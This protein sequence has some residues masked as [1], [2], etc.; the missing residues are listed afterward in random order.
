MLRAGTPAMT[1]RIGLRALGFCLLALGGGALHAAGDAAPGDLIFADGFESGGFSAWAGNPLSSSATLQTSDGQTHTYFYR[2]PGTPAPAGGRPVLLWLH[3]DGGSG[4]GGFGSQFYPYTDPDGAIV[5]TPSGI[6]QTW[7]HAADDLPGQPQDSQFLSLLIDDLLANGL[8]GSPVDPTRIYLGGVSRGAYMPY[9]LLQRPSTKFRFAA[10]AV[11]AGLLYCQAGDVDCDADDSSPLHHDA[12]TPILH[13]HGTDDTQVEPPPT[14]TFHFPID[15]SVDWRVFWPM[16][17][18]AAQHGCFDGANAGG[19]DDGILI[20]SYT[21]NGHPANVYD[22]TG[23]GAGCAKYRLILVT[24]GGHVIANQEGRI[25]AF[26]RAH[27]LG[28]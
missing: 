12:P 10:V 22:L 21:A 9:F 7:T 6:N 27:V 3:G 18:W 1:T 17:F 16:K 5:V 28:E 23:W 11:N 13:L 20:E 15:W 19:H 8:A 4:G 26:L 14:S 25:W 24:D 2:I